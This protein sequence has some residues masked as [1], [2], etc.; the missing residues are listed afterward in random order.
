MRWIVPLFNF[1]MFSLY[2]KEIIEHDRIRLKRK[3]NSFLQFCDPYQKFPL[4]IL[5][6][7]KKKLIAFVV[8]PEVNYNSFTYICAHYCYRMMHRNMVIFRLHLYLPNEC[9]CISCVILWVYRNECVFVYICLWRWNFH[10]SAI[11]YQMFRHTYVQ[12]E[13]CNDPLI[14]DDYAKYSIY[15]HDKLYEKSNINARLTI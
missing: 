12:K 6:I 4:E 10:K 3:H 2:W 14:Y 7:A 11:K 13:L 15:T 1:P 8:V 5:I 9:V